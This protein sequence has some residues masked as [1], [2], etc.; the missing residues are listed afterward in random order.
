MKS[1]RP[2]MLQPEIVEVIHG[3][4]NVHELVRRRHQ[5]ILLPVNTKA[6]NP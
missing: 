5:G 6:L 4:L 1:P 2:M 3:K